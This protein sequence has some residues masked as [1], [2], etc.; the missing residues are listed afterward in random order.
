MCL[1]YGPTCVHGQVGHTAGSSVFGATGSKAHPSSHPILRPHFSQV[2]LGLYTS[3]VWWSTLPDQAS[4]P[5]EFS[6]Q[7]VTKGGRTPVFRP[8]QISTTV[9]PIQCICHLLL[10]SL[11]RRLP[12]C[13]PRAS[14]LHRQVPGA[15]SDRGQ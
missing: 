6:I 1:L 2:F 15:R 7:T 13:L 9:T 5:A 8:G 11:H 3:M 4:H 10:R 12:S 14:V